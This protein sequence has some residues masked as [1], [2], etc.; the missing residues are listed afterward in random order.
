MLAVPSQSAR[1]AVHAAAIAAE[2]QPAQA[3][4]GAQQL[5]RALGV[6][7]A[8]VL[9]EEAEVA[10]DVLAEHPAAVRGAADVHALGAREEDHLPARLAEAVGPVRLLAEEEERLVERADLLHGL[11]PDEHAGAHQELR[12]AHLLMVEAARVE[13]VQRL[14]ARRQLAEEE[15]L[16][17]EPPERREAANRPL[18]RAVGVEQP[19]PDDRGVR[20]LVGEGDEPAQRALGQPRVR[21]QDQEVAARRG[22]H[23]AVPAGREADVLLLDH[24]CLGQL[25]ADD[26]RAAVGRAV[27]DD[28]HLLSA[29]ALEAALD[30]G[31]RVVRD[32]DDARVRHGARSAPAR[33]PSQS[34]ISPP[35]SAITTVTRKKRKPAAKAW[36]ASTPTLPRKLT[37][38]ASRTAK[39]LSVNG[40]SRTRKKSG[41]IT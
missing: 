37:K 10:A 21:V 11:A 14:R 31:E 22:L 18:Q 4:G 29:H 5:P 39:P 1:L 38:N 12:L 32:D 20:V 17:G 36:S 7:V 25:L 3:R 16:G 33:S 15:V 2:E 26:V 19:R 9:G 8:V 34:R 6:G 24:A 35:G 30:P 41:P 23:A 40:T 27:V 13:P 28:D